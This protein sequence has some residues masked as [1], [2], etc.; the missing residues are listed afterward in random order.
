M[1]TTLLQE[2]QPTVRQA[3]VAA[4]RATPGSGTSFARRTLDA[5][6]AD[7]FDATMPALRELARR[8]AAAGASPVL[9]GVLLSGTDPEVARLRA[10]ARVVAAVDTGSGG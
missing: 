1:T 8:G 6:L 7:G 10:L 5:V 9:L 4:Q 2:R 3:R